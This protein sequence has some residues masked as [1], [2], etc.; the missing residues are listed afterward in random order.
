MPV[1]GL[2]RAI[3]PLYAA[4]ELFLGKI[5]RHCDQ[6]SLA[7]S[8][9]E[10]LTGT[11]PYIGKNARQLLMM[12]TQGEP[13]LSSLRMV[14]CGGSAVPLSLMKAFEERHGVRI[15]QAWGMT[16]TSPLGS[17]ARAPEGAEGDEMW[18]FRATAGR[19]C[20]PK[21]Q[22]NHAVSASPTPAAGVHSGSAEAP[23]VSGPS[24]NSTAPSARANGQRG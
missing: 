14:V 9:Q 4:P 2:I 16:E 1:L 19:I 5:S 23:Q 20:P 6:Y 13:D 3:T 8:F 21:R 10:L 12:H 24:S 18:S 22:P 17:V 15:T 7:I 11:L